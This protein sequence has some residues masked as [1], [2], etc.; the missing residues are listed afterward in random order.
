MKCEMCESV[1]L[2][3]K[4]LMKELEQEQKGKDNNA[5]QNIYEFVAECARMSFL[6]EVT[7]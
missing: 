4:R 7:K 6:V 3:A 1:N 2:N 5:T